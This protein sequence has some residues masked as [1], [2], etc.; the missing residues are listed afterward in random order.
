MRVATV[1]TLVLSTTLSVLAAP[2]VNVTA[3][4]KDRQD[5]GCYALSVLWLLFLVDPSSI[6]LSARHN[7]IK[8]LTVPLVKI[9]TAVSTPPSVNARMA[10]IFL[11]SSIYTYS[12]FPPSS[13]LR[14]CVVVSG[15]HCIPEQIG[16]YY[17]Y[18]PDSPG[19]CNPPWGILATSESGLGGYCCWLSHWRMKLDMTRW[20][21]KWRFTETHLDDVDLLTVS[22]R[23]CTILPRVGGI[24]TA[25]SLH[26]V[27][28]NFRKLSPPRTWEGAINCSG[29][30]HYT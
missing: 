27:V 28:H 19:G 15:W 4:L 26:T 7:R 8:V 5:S 14:V 10:R 22:W 23:S 17:L 9:Q 29:L 2:A 25:M 20:G 11:H 12:P 18:D 13:L 1:I 16:W 24:H 30:S 3:I 21:M 6:C